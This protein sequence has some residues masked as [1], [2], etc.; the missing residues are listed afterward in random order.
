V[1]EP[2]T[3]SERGTSSS[4]DGFLSYSHAADDLL[5]PRLQAG[6]Q[7][8]AKPW[9]KRR[10][11]RVFR[12]EASLTANPHLWSSI[13]DALDN[14]GWFVLLLSPDAAQSEWVNREIDYWTEHK[15]PGRILPVVTDGEF[16]WADGDVAGDAVPSSLR[17][18]F[19]DEPR[20]VDLRFARTESQLDLR[21]TKFR[22]AVADIAAAV[23]GVAK[24]E[25]ESEEIRQHR[26][27]VRTAWTAGLVILLL[28]IASTVGTIVALNAQQ[29]AQD[30]RDRA[31]AAELT[32][33]SRAESEREART[34]AEQQR[35][36]AE[37]EAIRAEAEK[38]RAD[39]QAGIAQ[40]NADLAKSRELAAAAVSVLDEDPELSM[41]LALG[42]IEASSSEAGASPS[43]VLVL[44]EALLANRL[45]YR[46]ANTGGGSAR[47]SPD[48]TTIFHGSAPDRSV[49]AI[50]VETDSPLWTYH[51]PTTND[52]FRAISVSPDGE[53]IAVNLWDVPAVEDDTVQL[54][55]AGK[56]PYPARTVVLRAR[57]G[58]V[59]TVIETSPCPFTVSLGNGFSPDGRWYSVW[60]GTEACA[61]LAD[62]DWIAVYDTTTWEERHRLSVEGGAAERAL[63]SGDS[64]RVLIVACGSCGPTPATEL[65]SFP[66]FSLINRLDDSTW[67]A[68]SPDGR[69]VVQRLDTGASAADPPLLVDG[70]T[71]ER[72]NFLDAA[73]DALTGY[74]P[75]LF[76]P[77]GSKVAVKTRGMDYVFETTRG[78]LI[79]GLA[80]GGETLEHSFTADGSKLLT[81]TP[82]DVLLWDLTD[83]FDEAGIEIELPDADAEWINRNFVIDGPELAVRLMVPNPFGGSAF[84]IVTTVLEPETG[85]VTASMFGPGAQLGDGRF[86]VVRAT[87][88][89][90]EEDWLWGPIVIWDPATDST[91]RVTDCRAEGSVLKRFDEIVCAE[92]EPFFGWTASEAGQGYLVASAEGEYFAATSYAPPGGL[93]FARVWDSRTLDVRSEFEIG[94]FDELMVADDGRIAI[95]HGLQGSVTIYD[96]DTTQVLAELGAGSNLTS[97]H[98]FDGERSLLYVADRSGGVWVFDTSTWETVTTW[99]AH[100]AGIR[101][102]AVS[103]DGGRLATTGDDDFVRIWHVGQ[104][105]EASPAAVLPG[106]LDRIPAPKP[107][108]AAWLGPDRLAVFLAD[109]ARWLELSLTVED[110]VEAAERRLTRGFTEDECETYGIDLCPDLETIRNG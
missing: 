8:F 9:W 99:R 28:G 56:D 63:F 23:R 45:L 79:A 21:H 108:D 89:E 32:A 41:L 5:A 68:L 34:E 35:T 3:S 94:E 17:G 59:M 37:S 93:R 97:L 25:L 109:G 66:D 54:D 24:D 102:F 75:F 95:Y 49:T 46:L 19:T 33:E 105:D 50:D 76:S 44:R 96:V 72:I 15:D 31:V 18:V 64:S 88:L 29:D 12:D 107:S 30:E 104:I 39:E 26:R 80:D 58:E 83:E 2:V 62:E 36:L 20:W 84:Q 13:T 77:D 53:T 6:L 71:G 91:T 11:L 47:V 81:V 85:Q 27:T 87:L 1:D 106:L 52:S 51:D 100:D 61:G 10:A 69:L 74:V 78:R 82:A 55:E 14:S 92:G 43:G 86:V 42:S 110:L 57:D 38:E 4:Y 98:A 7:R 101:G 67:A 48:G 73:G 65:R 90:S 103:P 60:T 22:D 70:E 40:S 16:G